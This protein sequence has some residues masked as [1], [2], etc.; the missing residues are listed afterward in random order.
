MSGYTKLA[1]QSSHEYEIYRQFL[2]ENIVISHTDPGV[3]DDL[4]FT[5]G[6]QLAGIIRV[7]Q[8]ICLETKYGSTMYRRK[9][10][11]KEGR[12]HKL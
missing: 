11:K 3:E 12:G 5:V 7:E 4:C 10:R 6:N 1:R 2:N 8:N 9:E